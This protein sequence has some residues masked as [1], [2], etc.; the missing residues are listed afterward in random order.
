M[1]FSS[2]FNTRSTTPFNHDFFDNHKS[3]LL[4]RPSLLN[5]PS[6]LGR[7]SV[8]SSNSANPNGMS[9]QVIKMIGIA[10]S[11]KVFIAVSL[12]TTIAAIVCA[13]FIP[14]AAIALGV[15]AG[16]SFVVTLGLLGGLI[17]NGINFSNT[18]G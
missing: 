1:S 6:T 11:L 15:I 16:A 9:P 7:S 17:S 8:A 5:R 10:V 4:D 13:F 3:S 18:N 14:I 2:S 12:L